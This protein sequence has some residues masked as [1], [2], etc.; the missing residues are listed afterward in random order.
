MYTFGQA[1]AELLKGK[2]ITRRYWGNPKTMVY[3]N[4]GSMDMRS[5]EDIELSPE[6]AEETI[7]Q[8]EQD[9]TLNNIDGVPIELFNPGHEGTVTRFP[10]INMSLDGKTITGWLPNAQD[11]LSE[12]WTVA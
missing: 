10:N 11:L 12:D 9:G 4:K 6:D 7:K 8:N 1:M 5:V 2:G 3:L